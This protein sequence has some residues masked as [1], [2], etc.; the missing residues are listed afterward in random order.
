MVVDANADERFNNTLNA[1]CPTAA[2]RQVRR[3]CERTI[4]TDRWPVN[5]KFASKVREQSSRENPN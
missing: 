3:E 5:S 1:S 2:L 4:R